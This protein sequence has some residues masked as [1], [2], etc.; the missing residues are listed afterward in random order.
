MT[1]ERTWRKSERSQNTSDCIEVANTLTEMRDSKNTE[2]PTLRG[3]VS[4]LV[5]TVKAG[6]FDR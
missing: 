3:N 2:G 4:E 1:T 5:A 6:R